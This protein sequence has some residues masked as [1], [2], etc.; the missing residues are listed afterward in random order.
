MATPTP[1]PV[2]VIDAQTIMVVKWSI[3]VLASVIAAVGSLLCTVVCIVGKI[4]IKHVVH[5]VNNID[6][7][8][9]FL[10][11][12]ITN[13]DGCRES[14]QKAVAAVDMEHKIGG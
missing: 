12:T 13:C 5:K 7:K 4:I 8:L 6:N 9:D 3:K 2:P 14:V 1:I 10:F 11:Q